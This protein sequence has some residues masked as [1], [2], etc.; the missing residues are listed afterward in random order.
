MRVLE[1]DGIVLSNY[2][3]GRDGGLRSRLLFLQLGHALYL[4]L[5]LFDFQSLMLTSLQI[6]RGQ[7]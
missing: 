7:T 3:F 2:L 6:L 5:Y 4:R 1:P